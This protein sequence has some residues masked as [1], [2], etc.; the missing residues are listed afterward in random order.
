MIPGLRIIDDI[1]RG[2]PENAR[3]RKQLGELRSQMQV[4]QVENETLKAELK[5][6]K[7]STDEISEE[8]LRVMQFF[9]EQGGDL[10]IEQVAR[11]FNYQRSEAEFHCDFLME[12]GFV[13]QTTAGFGDSSGLFGLTSEGR[14]LAM[15]NRPRLLAS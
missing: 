12:N 5:A 6:S 9:F 14:T 10:S 4:L 11:R 2:L 1:L 3:L 15:K 7:P 8:A 13:T